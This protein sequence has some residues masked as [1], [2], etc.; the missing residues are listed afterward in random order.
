MTKTAILKHNTATTTLRAFH[1]TCQVRVDVGGKTTYRVIDVPQGQG[2]L[3]VVID[4]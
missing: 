2:L 3:N 4:V 1:G